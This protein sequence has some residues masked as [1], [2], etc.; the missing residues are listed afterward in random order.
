MIR[1]DHLLI[2]YKLLAIEILSK[3][4]DDL[5]P[6]Y[7]EIT[8]KMNKLERLAAEQCVK[9]C[10]RIHKG[11]VE[12]IT[13]KYDQSWDH[14]LSTYLTKK[15]K[16]EKDKRSAI[17]NIYKADNTNK[18]D[19]KLIAAEEAWDRRRRTLEEKIRARRRGFATRVESQ[20][21]QKYTAAE[22]RDLRV[23]M[24][25]QISRE[26]R[27]F[28]K[29]RELSIQK[30]VQSRNS[31]RIIERMTEKEIVYD[32]KI[33]SVEKSYKRQEEIYNRQWEDE[34]IFGAS[35]HWF[36]NDLPQVK[37][38]CGVAGVPLPVCYKT[39]K[40]RLERICIDSPEINDI[41]DRFRSGELSETTI[42]ELTVSKS[43]SI[44]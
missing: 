30:V 7:V 40:S 25:S 27:E 6:N 22:V 32:T 23:G 14:L 11:Q 19:Q 36:I 29:R 18:I 37:F 34:D 8:P 43:S 2:N 44:M 39:V 24:E 3:A 41:I 28:E 16:L 33:K 42:P 17:D 9:L 15:I 13:N 26:I 12:F 10:G 35:L 5:C 21:G 20:K 4:L 1:E 38:W 31:Y